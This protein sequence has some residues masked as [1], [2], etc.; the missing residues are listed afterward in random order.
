MIDKNSPDFSK[1]DF[2]SSYPNWGEKWLYG[3]P[4]AEQEAL[5]A[6]KQRRPHYTVLP[7]GSM[8]AADYYAIFIT[9]II[10]PLIIASFIINVILFIPI[11][12]ILYYYAC[13]DQNT[14]LSN[15]PRDSCQWTFICLFTTIIALPMIIW[16]IVYVLVIWLLI[17]ITGV[18]FLIFNCRAQENFV[19]NWKVLWPYL[20][21]PGTGIAPLATTKH[22]HAEAHGFGFS[23]PDLYLS[24][25]AQMNRQGLCELLLAVPQNA[26]FTPIFKYFWMTNPFLHNLEEQFTNQWSEQLDVDW[27]GK[28]T[29]ED[30]VKL[31]YIMERLTVFP[32]VD[33][34]HRKIID[35]WPFIG[36]YPPPPKSRSHQVVNGM[37][38]SSKEGTAPCALR[39]SLVTVTV[40]TCRLPDAVARSRVAHHGVVTVYLQY[41]N[42]WHFVTGEV[43]VNVRKDFRVEHPMWIVC[44]PETKLSTWLRDLVNKLFGNLGYLVSKVVE[45][46]PFSEEKLTARQQEM[47]APT[48]ELLQHEAKNIHPD[49]D[50][51]MQKIEMARV[52]LLEENQQ[53]RRDSFSNVIDPRNEL[54]S[55][56]IPTDFLE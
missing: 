23:L 22:K 14:Q 19:K 53:V 7:G 42:P 56:P 3:H 16:N 45:Y 8:H 38:F 20:G 17:P 37:Q 43:E 30:L 55:H 40:L 50:S 34:V 21:R 31:N 32:M 10:F 24:L 25:I 51:L 33:N 27:D 47:L 35:S 15:W 18:L 29:D 5:D 44:D 4:N 11:P 13:P 6:Q 26:A 49:Q 52:Q 36:I 1:D 54:T 9:I 2:E 39:N 28:Y 46:I 48:T 41:W 12:I